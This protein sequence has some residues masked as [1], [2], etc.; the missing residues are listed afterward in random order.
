M[1][2]DGEEGDDPEQVGDA[3]EGAAC[4]V[5]EDASPEEEAAEVDGGEAEPGA[6]KRGGF[7][8]QQDAGEEVGDYGETEL[9]YPAVDEG[10]GGEG[11]DDGTGH[12]ADVKEDEGCHEDG[13]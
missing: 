3:D 6:A 7:V 8:G 4:W 9:E 5:G 13:G 2:E 11:F 10:L 12:V 1:V